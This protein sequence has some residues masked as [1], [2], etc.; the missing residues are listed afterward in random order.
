MDLGKPHR[1]IHHAHSHI[2]PLSIM[3][4]GTLSPLSL[5]LSFVSI[6]MGSGQPAPP[7]CLTPNIT[8]LLLW[9]YFPAQSSNALFT[10]QS[11]NLC[12]DVFICHKLALSFFFF[13]PSA[14]TCRQR[15]RVRSP[16]NR[17]NNTGDHSLERVS[18]ASVYFCGV[19]FLSL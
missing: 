14:T 10:L 12:P 6:T 18:F 3:Q 8:T 1:V 15:Q 5:S 13:S 17:P 2:P 19:E 9:H 4:G 7:I 11:P 16:A